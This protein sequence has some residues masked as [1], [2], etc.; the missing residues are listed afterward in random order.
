MNTY[1]RTILITKLLGI[2]ELH[3]RLVGTISEE[4][5][6][7]AKYDVV[8]YD[9]PIRLFYTKTEISDS[10]AH[11]Q[12]VLLRIELYYLNTLTKLNTL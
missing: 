9:H 4:K 5:L 3:Q 7:L 11:Y 12:N 1:T 8:R 6:R 2:V 10:V